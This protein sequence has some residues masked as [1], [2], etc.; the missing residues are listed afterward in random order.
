MS[1]F[2][3]STHLLERRHK[4]N[5]DISNNKVNKKE[6]FMSAYLELVNYAESDPNSP[7]R[8]LKPVIPLIENDTY[9]IYVLLCAGNSGYSYSGNEYYA[10]ARRFPDS[11]KLIDEIRDKMM[12]IMDAELDEEIDYELFFDPITYLKAEELVADFGRDVLKTSNKLHRQEANYTFIHTD[13]GYD[14]VYNHFAGYPDDGLV[15][16]SEQGYGRGTN[17]Y[18]FAYSFYD[19]RGGYGTTYRKDVNRNNSIEIKNTESEDEDE[20]VKELADDEI[21]IKL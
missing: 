16:I 10:D 3:M 18:F 20:T 4:T 6:Q 13:F 15:G 14:E 5:M 11:E 12:E 9:Y 21:E 19:P 2:Y 8:G 7:I 17:A 1:P